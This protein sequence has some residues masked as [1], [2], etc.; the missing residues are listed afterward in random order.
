MQSRESNRY[1]HT[2]AN[3]LCCAESLSHAQLFVTPWTVAHQAPLSIGFPRQ[4]SWSGLPFPSPGD[5]PDPGIKP[6]L[7]ALAGGF[8]TTEPPGKTIL[9]QYK[10]RKKHFIIFK[11][12][13]FFLTTL[14]FQPPIYSTGY[15]QI[16]KSEKKKKTSL[17]LKTSSLES[18]A[19]KTDG[20]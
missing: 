10:L 7:P 4:E 15:Q 13:K 18:A 3:E 1:L 19:Q 20:Q 2:S 14:Y 5:L 12:Q 16:K 17:S 9:S 11:K 8:F 6:R